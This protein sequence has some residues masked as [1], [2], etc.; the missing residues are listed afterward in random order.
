M[1]LAGKVAV[2]TG[3]GS[4]IG[5]GIALCL[6]Q[7]GANIAIPDLQEANAQSVADEV[8]ALG[9]AAIGLRCDVTQEADIRGTLIGSRRSWG[10]LTSS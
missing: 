3:G 8:R 9:H 2:V 5:R 7:E 10:K 6:A 4:G 1:K